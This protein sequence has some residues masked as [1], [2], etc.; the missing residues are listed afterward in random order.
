MTRIKLYKV[1]SLA[2]WNFQKM[3]SQPSH[4]FNYLYCRLHQ[5]QIKIKCIYMQITINGCNYTAQSVSVILVWTSGKNVG[6]LVHC[7]LVTCV[8]H[9]E[10]LNTLNKQTILYRTGQ[11]HITPYHTT[12]QHIVLHKTI[13]Y[14][15]IPMDGDG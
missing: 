3:N 12:P 1:T 9:T 7:M 15:T 4:K 14:H 10:D 2:K 8:C 5:N 6:V 13:P 11:F